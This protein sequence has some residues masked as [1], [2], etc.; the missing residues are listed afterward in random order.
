MISFD[1]N[2]SS[3]FD[4][5]DVGVTVVDN[6][7]RVLYVNAAH[8]KSSYY[9]YD[10]YMALNSRE[11]YE[12]GVASACP[13]DIIEKTKK[14]LVTIMDSSHGDVNY[15]KLLTSTPVFDS[16]GS[17][18]YLVNTYIDL[19]DFLEK[20]SQAMNSTLSP[21]CIQEKSGQKHRHEQV[22][23]RSDSMQKLLDLAE[24]VAITDSPALIMGETGVG[25]QV[26]A[27]FL[28]LK[29]PRSKKE[30]VVVNCASLPEQLLESELFGY[31]KGS[32]TGA[33]LKGKEGLIEYADKG[34][35]FLDEINS[36]PLALQAKLLRVLETKKVKRIG[37][38]REKDIDFRIVAASNKDLRVCI[39]EGTFRADLYY[40]LNVV[41]LIIPPLRKR[42]EDI[43]PLCNY[44]LSLFQNKYGKVKFLS[45]QAIQTLMAY[46]W[47]GNVRE[48]RNLME[49]LVIMS[50]DSVAEINRIPQ[51][52]FDGEEAYYS[53]EPS[54]NTP[55][56][57]DGQEVAE[58]DKIIIA[59]QAC[60][61]NRADAANYLGISRRTLQYKLKKHRI[62]IEMEPKIYIDN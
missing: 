52:M 27:D 33:S 13:L 29:S 51:E 57:G 10:E 35:L 2:A 61:G 22:V 14:Q 34:T 49:R 48:L 37:A 39:D 3:L 18:Q 26:I 43:I 23:Y 1:F 58:L 44:F 62:R 8:I 24:A 11:L 30:L 19:N 32:F 41:P 20:Y 16:Y 42:R 21:I 4:N 59:L 31:E 7:G 17:V 38:L 54:E 56:G 36:M 50:D 5:L 9:T 53:T 47:P 12:S 40:R 15:R 46:S 6:T 25:K 60:S 28:H 55:V 45:A